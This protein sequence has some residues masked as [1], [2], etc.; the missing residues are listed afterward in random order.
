MLLDTLHALDGVGLGIGCNTVTWSVLLLTKASLAHWLCNIDC[1]LANPQGKTDR[2]SWKAQWELCS[3]LPCNSGQW[4]QTE[5]PVKG[6]R[7]YALL[8]LWPC[9]VCNQQWWQCI[10]YHKSCCMLHDPQ[11]QG[12]VLLFCWQLS[13]LSS[14]HELWCRDC[15]LFNTDLC[16]ADQWCEWCEASLIIA[17]GNNGSSTSTLFMVLLPTRMLSKLTICV[18]G[19]SRHV[20][21]D[22]GKR[23][24]SCHAGFVWRLAMLVLS[25]VSSGALQLDFESSCKYF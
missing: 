6:G 16:Q 20:E 15:M 25:T 1:H 9:T 18:V 23:K 11:P 12:P 8:L 21:I 22:S 17:W 13:F 2:P 4:K 24:D 7:L 19:C 14:H 3:F 5:S 10:C